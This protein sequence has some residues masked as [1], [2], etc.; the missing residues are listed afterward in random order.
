[1]VSLTFKR[2]PILSR[3]F[4][5]HSVSLSLSCFVYS[6]VRTLC[7]CVHALAL[8]RILGLLQYLLIPC[9]SVVVS[10]WFHNDDATPSMCA[11]LS[12][13]YRHRCNEIAGFVLSGSSYRQMRS[14]ATHSDENSQ[15]F[16][17]IVGST[18]ASVAAS[19]RQGF[20]PRQG[21]HIQ[22]F[23]A[24]SNRHYGISRY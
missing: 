8:V 22:T 7:V 11:K 12:R 13:L 19:D 2:L 15:C 14:H 9:P 16:S 23:M 4:L 21:H 20:S 1:M 10:R 17:F 3:F 6:A 24:R 5:L 18:T